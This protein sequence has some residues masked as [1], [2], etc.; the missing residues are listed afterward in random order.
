MTS[1]DYHLKA[2]FCLSVNGP[3]QSGKSSLTLKILK[4]SNEII[5]PSIDKIIYCYT[6]YQKD[7]FGKMKASIPSISFHE[8]LPQD[9]NNFGDGQKL[10]V[11]DDLMSEASKSNDVTNAFTRSSHH[12]NVSIIFLTQNLFFKDTRTMSLN[13]KYIIIMKN[14]RDTTA[15]QHLGRQMNGGRKNIV[16]ENAYKDIMKKPYGYLLIDYDQMQDDCLR[17]RDSIFP[18][19]CTIYSDKKLCFDKFNK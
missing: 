11:L 18:Q 4:R 14:P 6:E 9:Y 16:M 15:I 12:Q 2:P 13:C 7:L 3:S 8:G 10:I 19:D 1:F 17:I 5:K